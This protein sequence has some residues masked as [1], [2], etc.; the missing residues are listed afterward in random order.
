[1]LDN[2]IAIK[3]I[4][5]AVG[6]HR[7][8]AVTEQWA[9]EFTEFGKQASPDVYIVTARRADIYSLVLHS[10]ILFRFLLGYSAI[11]QQTL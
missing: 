2:G 6:K 11:A 10:S 5:I 7:K 8:T 1:M 4:Y 9:Y 3:S